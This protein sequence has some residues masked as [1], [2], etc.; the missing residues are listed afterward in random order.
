METWQTLFLT[1]ILASPAVAV[2]AQ[3]DGQGAGI[4]TGDIEMSAAVAAARQILAIYWQAFE[5]P[6][7]QATLLAL[8]VSVP[9]GNNGN[10]HLW[11]DKIAAT[12]EGGYTGQLISEPEWAEMTLGEM[13]TFDESKISDWSYWQDD[14]LHGNYTTRAMLPHLT[15]EEAA[16]ISAL[17][18]PLPE[19]A[20]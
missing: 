9:F 16:Q 11:V 2:H 19:D 14:H 4:S 12:A 6:T 15:P 20:P 17:L 7:A 3:S 18:A 13:I 1:L 5:D 10:E 8:K